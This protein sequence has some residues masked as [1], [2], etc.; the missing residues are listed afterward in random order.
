MIKQHYWFDFISSQT[1][2]YKIDSDTTPLLTP[3]Y[4]GRF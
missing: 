4:E 2:H 1:K 3:Q